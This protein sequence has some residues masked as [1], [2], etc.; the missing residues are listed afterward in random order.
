M[1]NPRLLPDRA[2]RR[3]PTRRERGQAL[4][5]IAVAFIGLAAFIG[6]AV[7]AGIL[8]TQIGHLR[9]AVDAA[10]LG[11]ANQFREGRLPAEL[12]AAATEF[13]NLNNVT[14]GTAVVKFCADPFVAEGVPVPPEN[15]D[16]TL[17]PTVGDPYRK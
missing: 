15:S 9:R 7:D 11:A 16:A 14:T 12:D 10:A 17:C 8:F 1:S 6:R 3:R 5:L 2:A 4:V 13:I